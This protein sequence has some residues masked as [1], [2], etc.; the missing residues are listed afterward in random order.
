MGEKRSIQIKGVEIPPLNMLGIA[1]LNDCGFVARGFAG[2]KDHLKKLLIKAIEYPGLSIL[3]IIQPCITWRT[4]PVKWYR[5]RIYRLGS[6]HDPENQTAA[7]AL[8]QRPEDRFPI[9]IYYCVTPRSAF[10]DHYRRATGS[11]A[12]AALSP[13]GKEVIDSVLSEYLSDSFHQSKG[14]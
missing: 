5:E 6:E 14:S 8:T 2:E 1:I 10:G 13:V 3:E 4:H 7:V 11:K 9:G 12:L